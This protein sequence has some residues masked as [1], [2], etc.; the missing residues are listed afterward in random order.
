MSNYSGTQ[1]SSL[2]HS[3][4]WASNNRWSVFSCGMVSSAI[5]V[6]ASARSSERVLKHFFLVKRLWVPG[7]T[8]SEADEYWSTIAQ[9]KIGMTEGVTEKGSVNTF[10]IP[11]L[12]AISPVSAP[13]LYKKTTY[14]SPVQVAQLECQPDMPRLWVQCPVRAHTTSTNECIS[15]WNNKWLCFSLSQSLPLK[16]N[17]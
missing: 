2:L 13:S 6:L 15:K 5:Q 14:I 12:K 9:G 4:W 11:P 3:E 16:I 7:L 17:K 8:S 1:Q 10:P